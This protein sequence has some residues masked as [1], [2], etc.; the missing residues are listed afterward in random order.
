[1]K[2][3]EFQINDDKSIINQ[4]D[5]FI[6]LVS[7]LKD[8]KVDVF[9]Q[10]QVTTLITKLPTTWNDYRKKLLHITKDFTLTNSSSISTLK[11]RL[12]FVRV[13]MLLRLIQK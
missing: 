13:S 11:K 7:R 12:A 2:F 3:F 10:L 1:M 8:L 9:E 6:I 5:K 4:V